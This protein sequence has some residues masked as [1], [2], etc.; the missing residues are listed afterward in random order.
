MRPEATLRACLLGA[1]RHSVRQWGRWKS[2][3]S[4]AAQHNKALQPCTQHPVRPR[5]QARKREHKEG[6][7]QRRKKNKHTQSHAH[8]VA[9]A[10]KG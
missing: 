9:F 1:F 5:S 6:T 2:T 7:A 10:V 4:T 3:Y 8:S